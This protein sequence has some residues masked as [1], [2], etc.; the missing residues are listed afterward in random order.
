M[1]QA[2]IENRIARLPDESR[3]LERCLGQTLREEVHA[4]RENPPFDRVCMDGIAISSIGSAPGAAQYVVEGT[5]QAGVPALALSNSRAAIEVMTGAVMPTGADCVIPL[6][7][8]ELADR[9]ARV[10]ANALREPYRN[11]QRR[12]AD[13]RPGMPMLRSG[14]RLNAPEIAIIASAGMASV[15]V[16]RQPKVMVVSTGDELIDPGKPIAQHQVRRSNA[17]AVVASLMGHGFQEVKSDHIP[18]DEGLLRERLMRH[19]AASDLLILSGGVSK[20]KFDFVPKVLKELG[21][22]EV[23]HKVAQ[24]PGMPMW[25]GMTRQGCAVFGLPGNPIATL[26]CLVRYVVPALM[27]AMGAQRAWPVPVALASAI[28]R[29]RTMASFVPVLARYDAQG[30]HLAEPRIPNGSG[31]FL[32][33]AGTDGFVELAPQPDGYPAGSVAPMYRW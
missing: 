1:A 18:D 12:G 27:T 16:S 28:S 23:F 8:Y 10:Q 17:Y 7:E 30:R 15:R 33:L 19:V 13:S 25:F 26:V 6:E 11:V 29:G 14:V 3:P 24:R 9:I 31:D 21:V 4:E 32:A 5:Q 22:E 2:A 20:G